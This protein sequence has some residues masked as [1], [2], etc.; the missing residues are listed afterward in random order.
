M[1]LWDHLASFESRRRWC[2]FR[3]VERDESRL[4]EIETKNRTA[5]A[6]SA[7]AHERRPSRTPKHSSE[8]EPAE[9]NPA[10]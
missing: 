3:M 6:R 9:R 4:I 7:A 10:K 1:A 5:R 8:R 2:E